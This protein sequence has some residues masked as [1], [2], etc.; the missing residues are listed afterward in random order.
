MAQTVNV[1]EA[2]THLSGL[3]ARVEQGEEIVIAR[4]GRP[5]ARLIAFTRRDHERTPGAWTG[6][7]QIG[8]DFDAFGGDDEQLWY[9]E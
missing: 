5:V 3:L 2:K 6:R 4:H 9:G 7:I 1:Y 8:A